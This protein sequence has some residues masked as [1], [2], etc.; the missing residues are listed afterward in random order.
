MKSDQAEVRNTDVEPPPSI[1]RL[2]GLKWRDLAWR[3][4][5]ELVY[6]HILVHAAALAFYFL[7]ALFPLLIF[8]VNLT[9]FFVGRG[10]EMRRS[11]LAYIR[12][13]APASAFTLIS[14]LIDEIA[15]G[16][17]GGKLLLG[18]I[19][20][21]WFGS[22]GVAALS[23]S[24]NAM[25]GVR[26]TR[27]WL[28]VRAAA[29][30][31]T[32][33]L[34]VVTLT[35]LLMLA[36]GH[37]AGVN[38]AEALGF[39]RSFALL[40]AIMRVPLAIVFVLLAFAIVYY[41]T[42]DLKDQKWYWITPGS[43]FGVA[44]WLAASTVLSTYL[45][46]ADTYSVTYGSLGGVIVMMLWFYVTGASILLGGKIN[47]EIENAAAKAGVPG[48]KLH[49]ERDPHEHEFVSGFCQTNVLALR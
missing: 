6:G 32:L 19:A 42:P 31:L 47:S 38:I 43:L 5:D 28:R 27:S 36:Y 11:L 37:Q 22:L 3:V 34:L 30:G 17:G 14:D 18:L 46:Y 4:W 9:G 13:L 45:R 24:L 8:L 48:A 33:V 15:T 7:F 12:Q 16:A 44:L 1:W 2:G 20:A 41:F 49:G 40:W 26:E 39:S 21:M 10:T 35:A 25:Y 29:A 23:E